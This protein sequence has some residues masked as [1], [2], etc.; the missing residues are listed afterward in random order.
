MTNQLNISP[1]NISSNWT[2]LWLLSK[3]L[4]FSLLAILLFTAI[5]AAI[6]TVYI[7]GFGLMILFLSVFFLLKQNRK[8]AVTVKVENQHLQY[9]CPVKKETISIQTSE[10][11]KV[12]SQFCE[13]QIHTPD[14]TYCLNL[15]NIRQE[16]QRWEIKETIK[17]L[18]PNEPKKAVNY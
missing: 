10:I 8:P 9:F 11:V 5:V 3:I 2:K 14:H 13:L 15:N 7:F 6:P 18:V 1:Q 4:L 17:K 12:T 16:K